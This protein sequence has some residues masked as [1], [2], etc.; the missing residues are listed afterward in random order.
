M[1]AGRLPG[2]PDGDVPHLCLCHRGARLSLRGTL[3]TDD[4]H[5]KI[6]RPCS[7]GGVAAGDPA[8]HAPGCAGAGHC[9]LS[10]LPGRGLQ[11]W[12]PGDP[13]RPGEPLS[14]CRHH[15]LGADGSSYFTRA[16]APNDNSKRL[17]KTY[18]N[19]GVKSI[20]V[21][22][23]FNGGANLSRSSELNVPCPSSQPP[24]GGP[25]HC[26][27]DGCRHVPYYFLENDIADDQMA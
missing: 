4:K 16:T 13:V 25:I 8:S 21:T 6:R 23:S 11:G 10:R 2:R 5:R 1:D 27:A 19:C 3:I 20:S 7:R 26:F 14:S 22:V 24:V 18:D 12:R 9:R 17:H 15:R